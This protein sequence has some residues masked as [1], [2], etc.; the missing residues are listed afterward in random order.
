MGNSIQ[1][2]TQAPAPFRWNDGLV[3][4]VKKWGRTGHSRLVPSAGHM[5]RLK[6]W[7]HAPIQELGTCPNLRT[8]HIPHSKSWAH[9]LFHEMCAYTFQEM[10]TSPVLG[11][12]TCHIP[13]AG[14]MPQS[15]NT[16]NAAFLEQ[17]TRSDPQARHMPYSKSWANALFKKLGICP[18]PRAGHM[19]RS[20]RGQRSWACP[21]PAN[22]I[23]Q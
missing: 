21:L 17:S 11:E 18:A 19:L 8:G 1:I 5:P 7:A 14:H 15:E 23:T 4:L 22:K 9:V 3:G 20:N 6:S 13:R 16:K 2:L 12:C 10:G